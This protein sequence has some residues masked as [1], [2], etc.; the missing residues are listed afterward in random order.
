MHSATPHTTAPAPRFC[1][2][3]PR[4]TGSLLGLCMLVPYACAP[5]P[6]GA[7]PVEEEAAA[8][9]LPAGAEAVSL[10]G[11]TLYAG[12]RPADEL[13]ELTRQQVEARAEYEASPDEADA[14]IWLGRRTA[15]LSRYREAIEVYTE[16]IAKHP[17]DPRMYRHR[18]HRFIS[19]RQLD[20]AVDDLERAAQLI[21]GSA[22][23]IEPD[24]QPNARNIPTSTLH[25]NIWYH[26]GLALYLQGDFEGAL[27]AYRQC[28][29][30][31]RNPDMLVA[32]SH[33]LYMTLRRLG[34]DAEAAH[35]LEPIHAGL[36]VIENQSYHQLLLMYKGELDPDSLWGNEGD[37]L[38]NATVGY[39]IGNWHLYN[40]RP[41][42]AGGVFR[43]VLDTGQWAAF[44][45]LASEAELSRLGG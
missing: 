28:M 10:L 38:G 8:V 21:E 25:S 22:D 2:P 31:S 45:Y 14:I 7:R 5:A 33:W 27:A 43:R 16:G 12:E 24:G 41:G 3:T 11:D 4:V 17:E 40:D 34:A 6:D 39:G 13:A 9:A 30:V 44:G 32:T 36:D 29:E 15:Y 37:A 19:T 20:R 35:I 1:L 23:E 26:L 42:E 18:G